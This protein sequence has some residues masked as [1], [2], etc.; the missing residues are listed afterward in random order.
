[1]I[2]MTEIKSESGGNIVISNEILAVIA[3]K[4][5]L[6]VEG[7]VG[8]G[9]YFPTTVTNKTVRKH[10][11]KGV[12]VAVIDESAKV[13]VAIKVQMG[14]KLHEI[15]KEVQTRVKAAIETMTGL[16]VTEVNVRVAAIAPEKR[17]A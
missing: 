7:V 3:G 16:T 17:K 5:A 1:M 13:G 4:A 2:D 11:P 9:G 8:I 12:A 10:M 14:V 15:S 6:E